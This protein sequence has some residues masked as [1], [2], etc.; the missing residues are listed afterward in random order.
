[1]VGA[2]A[3]LLGILT[4]TVPL[5]SGAE[6]AA[7][8]QDW[9]AEALF[10]Y[11]W[12]K[13]NITEPN[14]PQQRF[15]RMNFT[16]RLRI[17]N[18]G[19]IFDPRLL[20][21]RL[22][23]TLGLF[24]EQFSSAGDHASSNGNLLGF[25]TG[26]LLLEGKPYTLT[27]F[28]NRSEDVLTREFAGT[29]KVLLENYGGSL[30]LRE[31]PLRSLLGFRRERVRQD[32]SF[33]LNSLK[34]EEVR[35]IASYQGSRLGEVSDFDVN[36]EF[37]DV[38]D[39]VS[40]DLSFQSHNGGLSY[41]HF[42]GPYLE[43]E[44]LSRLRV[45]DRQGRFPSL[46]AQADENLRIDHTDN[47]ASL[48][49]YTVLFNTAEQARNLAH[50][51]A[52]ALQH[53]L[54]GSLTSNLRALG[55]FSEVEGG[56]TFGYGGNL[57]LD[58]SKRIPFEGR[59]SA[60]GRTSYRID[61]QEF[62]SGE[63]FVF[64]ERH[65]IEDFELIFLAN[66]RVV[67]STIF[68]MDETGAPFREGF[69][70][71][72]VQIG[73]LTALERVP[74]G[75]FEDGKVILVD[76]QFVTARTLE[77]STLAHGFNLA[78]DYDWISLF[79]ERQESTQSLLSGEDGVFLDDATDQTAGTQVRWYRPE[80]QASFLG[81]YRMYDSTLVAYTSPRFVQ[82]LSLLPSPILVCNATV[83]ETFFH[84]SK[85]E[86]RETSSLLGRMSATWRPLPFL[87]A[88]FYSSYLRRDDTVAPDEGLFDAGVRVQ[89]EFGRLRLV[90]STGFARR[91]VGEATTTELRATLTVIRQL[92]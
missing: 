19:F 31:A 56:R 21:F 82:S 45:F 46:F 22:G 71:T 74:S 66:P 2:A 38:I 7:G 65:V 11:E 70:Y 84:F 26:A 23:A 1:V 89:V 67:Q 91:E 20:N 32:L 4:C 73:E 57:G 90:P 83:S 86:E 39:Q 49:D 59:L 54:F 88:E 13:Q 28:G 53:R 55:N 9:E 33:G 51:G 62:P 61:N 81:E 17:G 43:K 30:T 85:P 64:Q 15:E 78:V 24:Q 58:Y 27:V 14:A 42:F 69:D 92:F 34:R 79:F 40:R 68:V 5:E 60:G 10:G 18:R 77:F 8:L 16:E 12:D 47:F 3:L 72:V 35:S 87:Y 76:Y 44:W 63:Q 37:E 6:N 50:L 48:Y 41:R 80:T 52:I 75:R 36:Y 29:S 25:D